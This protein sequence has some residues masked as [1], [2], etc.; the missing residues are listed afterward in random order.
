MASMNKVILCGNLTRDPEKRYIPSGTAVA[1]LGLAVNERV[2][3]QSGEWVEKPVYV[4]IVV[5]DRTAENCAQYLSKGSPILVEGRLQLDQWETKEGEKRNKL[6][7][8]GDNV[9][10][11]SARGEGGGGSRS[12]NSGAGYSEQRAPA[13]QS[14]PPPAA[15]PASADED[16]DL[17]F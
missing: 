12:D 11:L 13:Q 5:W 9:Q 2:K 7:V 16:D 3:N 14:A 6:R 17:P 15:P 10:F 1:E 8:R 4:D